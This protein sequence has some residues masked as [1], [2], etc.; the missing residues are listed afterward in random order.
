MGTETKRSISACFPAYNEAANLPTVVRATDEVLRTVADAYEII[1]V[2][3]GSTDDTPEVLRTL[4]ATYPGLR[5]VRHATN[6]G[7][8]A[9]VLTGLRAAR[10]D[11]V[12]FCDADDQFDVRELPKLL[13]LIDEADL[14]TGY[15]G[16]RRDPPHRRLNALLWGTLV[17][18]A[19]GV[20]VRDL[21]CAFKLMRRDTLERA[22]L[23]DMAATGAAL[24]AE[25]LARLGRVGARIREV[26]VTHRPRTHG[27]QTGASPKVIL[28]AFKETAILYWR[29]RC[30][31]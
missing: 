28:R 29:L 22:G 24:N 8:G 27:T 10:Q 23:H 11:L 9:A 25:L 16:T 2:D 5:A 17:R 1:V 12:F 21:N 7:Y 30:S 18:V 4:A 13:A 3:D 15:R 19:F 20:T 14:V 26:D 6:A 31:R